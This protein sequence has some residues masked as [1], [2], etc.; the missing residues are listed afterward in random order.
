MANW[1]NLKSSINSVIKTNANQEITGQVLQN[2]L[3]TIVSTVGENATYVGVATPSTNP[4]SPDGNVFYFATQAG[5]YANFG[6]AELEVGLTI[7]LWNGSNWTAT[8]VMTIKQEVGS[9]ESSVMSQRIITNLV[10]EY[11]VSVNHPTEGIDGGNK[12]TLETAIAKVGEEL[13]HAGL[14]VTFLNEEGTTET[15]EYQGGTFTNAESW[16][17][18]DAVEVVKELGNNEKAVVSQKTVTKN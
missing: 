12:Y 15:W 17:K 8:K 7:L 5:T 3:N 18:R 9:S 6:G 10:S 11:N 14:K 13:R 16:R 4:G 2:V 1:S